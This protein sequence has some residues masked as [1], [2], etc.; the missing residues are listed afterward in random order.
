MGVFTQLQAI[1]QVDSYVCTLLILWAST[2]SI[3]GS[4]V[5]E[6]C[7][8]AGGHLNT[9]LPQKGDVE[10]EKK[11]LVEDRAIRMGSALAPQWANYPAVFNDPH[12]Q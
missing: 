1:A 9:L 6:E 7:S 5:L 12:I 10:R 11:G 3:G 8:F 2:Q 4:T